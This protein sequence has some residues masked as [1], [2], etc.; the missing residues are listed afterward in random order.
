EGIAIARMVIERARTA[1]TH[2][3]IGS[4]P[5][6][7]QHH[8][9]GRDRTHMLDEAREVESD[10]G[11]AGVPVDISRRDGS[12]LAERVDLDD[13]RRDR[14]ARRLPHEPTA[15]AAREGKTAEK[16]EAPALRLDARRTDT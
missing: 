12:R 11:I 1:V 16:S 2:K 4:E 9:V 7:A 3:V 8:R 5:V 10:L 6:P 13:P 14:P 15:E